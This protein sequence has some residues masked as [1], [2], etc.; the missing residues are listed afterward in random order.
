V[1]VPRLRAVTW[2]RSSEKNPGSK[3][4]VDVSFDFVA[5][6]LRADG[7]PSGFSLIDPSG[8][9][10][11]WIFKITLQQDS[12]R[13]HLMRRPPPGSMITY[14]RGYRLRCNLT[15]GRDL[16]MPVFAK[17]PIGGDEGLRPFV[18]TWRVHPPVETTAFIDEMKKPDL[19][20]GTAETKTYP[21]GFINE[22]KSWQGK[23]GHAF[24]E[25]TV[26]L[27][28]ARMIEVLMGYDG[29]FRIWIN[30]RSFFCNAAG[31]N[32]C[33]PDENGKQI[34]LPAGRHEFL[35]GMD[36]AHGRT[37]GFFL[38]WRDVKAAS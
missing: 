1:R 24:F 16:A 28:Q 31:A 23:S 27:D 18:T 26:E 30:G 17:Q 33:L 5:D 32:P 4:A 29:P 8:M 11:L 38:R 15:D 2:A 7:E 13:L 10:L 14:G 37:W 6:G 20:S 21:D 25:T 9:E 34:T 3:C 19:V 12:A 35:V 22:H 36:I